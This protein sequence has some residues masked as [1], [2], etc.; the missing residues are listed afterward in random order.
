MKYRGRFSF[1][2]TELIA[3]C[4]HAPNRVPSWDDHKESLSQKVCKV[5]WRETVR[6]G[7]HF[8]TFF[9]NLFFAY[10]SQPQKWIWM[11]QTEL[12]IHW[13][14]DNI[15]DT[16]F[17][18]CVRWTMQSFLILSSLMLTLHEKK[19]SLQRERDTHGMNWWD[20]WRSFKMNA[21]SFLLRKIQCHCHIRMG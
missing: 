17:L 7:T 14:A 15:K 11:H 1:Q 19:N 9:P 2:Q 16:S 8:P 21:A 3:V 20:V 4:F 5:E 13:Q 18:Y 12:N 10:S 6:Q